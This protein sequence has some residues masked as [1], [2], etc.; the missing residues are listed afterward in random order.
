MPSVNATI[1]LTISAPSARI[2]L[3]WDG[4]ESQMIRW[5]NRHLTARPEPKAEKP[6]PLP[7]RCGT[8]VMELDRALG[9]TPAVFGVWRQQERQF[10]EWVEA[11]PNPTP[12]WLA[13]AQRLREMHAREANGILEVDSLSV[14]R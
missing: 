2:S 6:P 4:L 7:Y 5:L 14:T 10:I 1:A 9:K 12:E 3:Y 8:M 13:E 11:H